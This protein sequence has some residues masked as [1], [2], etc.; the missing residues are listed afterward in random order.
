MLIES[1]ERAIKNLR[2]KLSQ[3]DRRKLDVLN[4]RKWPEELPPPHN[5]CSVAPPV[6]QKETTFWKGP[7]TVR[8]LHFTDNLTE[9]QHSDVNSLENLSPRCANPSD[10]SVD[11][12]P[13]SVEMQDIPAFEPQ[14][15]DKEGDG[16]NRFD[17][18][19]VSVGS[20]PKWTESPRPDLSLDPVQQ[21]KVSCE[22]DIQNMI[23]DSKQIIDVE[24]E[25]FVARIWATVGDTIMPGHSYDIHGS[26]VGRKPPQAKETISFLRALS[27]P[28]PSPSTVHPSLTEVPSSQQSLTA[29]L[30]LCLLQ[31]SPRFAIPFNEVKNLLTL[32]AGEVSDG[33]GVVDAGQNTTRILYGCVAK[34][35]IKIERGKGEQIVKFDV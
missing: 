1:E 27:S 30:L 35:L 9:N 8:T 7:A 34:R 22:V 15:L 26:G 21:K 10:P 12:C 31:S 14:P 25:M 33:K 19:T 16:G 20:I 5:A 23:N 13:T 3:L 11:E 32:K 2:I 17:G 18:G 28:S 6:T 29:H 24:V 4:K